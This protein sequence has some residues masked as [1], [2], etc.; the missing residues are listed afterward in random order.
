MAL[1]D[2]R[3]LHF[4]NLSIKFHPKEQILYFA[5]EMVLFLLSLWL[6]TKNQ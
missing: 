2:T 4:V 6:E 3:G 1:D 5:S